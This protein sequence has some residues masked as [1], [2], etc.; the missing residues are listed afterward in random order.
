M[1]RPRRAA[2]FRDKAEQ[3][4]KLAETLSD[5]ASQKHILAIARAWDKLAADTE[6]GLF[7]E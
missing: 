4:R 3:C 2:Q 1:D 7:D 5:P 6:A